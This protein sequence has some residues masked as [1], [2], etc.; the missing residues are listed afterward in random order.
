MASKNIIHRYSSGGVILKDNRVL[1]IESLQPIKEYSFPKGSI[2]PG[3]HHR[4]T[5]VREILEETGYYTT[6]LGF[7]DT[8]IYEFSTGD[9]HVVKKVSYYAM[10]INSLVPR[11]RQQLQPGEDIR[12][13]WVSLPKAFQL[14]T[15]K[16]TRQLL[17]KAI[18]MYRH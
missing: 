7:I 9:G 18:K 13:L 5:A 16:N 6:I 12:P 4:D 17:A 15:H 10:S 11:Q 3:E 14:L 2:E 8:L 1:I